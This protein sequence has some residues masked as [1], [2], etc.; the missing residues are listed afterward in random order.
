MEINLKWFLTWNV[1]KR[2]SGTSNLASG[3]KGALFRDFKMQWTTSNSDNYLMSLQSSPPKN[4][5]ACF[6]CSF[7][8]VQWNFHDVQHNYDQSTIVC[9]PFSGP[10]NLIGTEP[11]F[12]PSHRSKFFS[13]LCMMEQID[14]VLKWYREMPPS[15]SVSYCKQ[16]F[17]L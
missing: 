14:V 11:A 3:R 5:T 17:K 2:G 7:A 8:V 16:A 10:D 9:W 15:V 12:F 4:A 13:L 1:F 6:N